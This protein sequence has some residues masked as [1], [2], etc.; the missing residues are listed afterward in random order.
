M[1]GKFSIVGQQYAGKDAFLPGIAPDT[2]VTLIREPDNA[3]DKNA[4]MV[5]I[6]GERVGYLSHKDAAKMAPY[7][8][9]VGIDYGT[10]MLAQDSKHAGA[11][12]IAGKFARSPNSSYPQVIVEPAGD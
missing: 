12:S 2:P 11:K 7:I 5:W 10:D 8:D 3:V 1:K 9:A 4:V 6:N